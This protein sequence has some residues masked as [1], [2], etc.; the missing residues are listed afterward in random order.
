[1]DQHKTLG[2]MS[3]DLSG[4]LRLIV[5]LTGILAYPISVYFTHSLISSKMA[6]VVTFYTFSFLK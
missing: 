4:L 5:Y 6:R 2:I 3:C 1:M